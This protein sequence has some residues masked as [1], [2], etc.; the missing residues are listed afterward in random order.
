MSK[1]K[2]TLNSFL[3][4]GL[5]GGL[6]L[7]WKQ[8]VGVVVNFADKNVLD[9]AITYRGYKFF[10]SFVYGESS[11]IGKEK[12]WECLMR[13]GVG[14]RDS[15]CMVGDF[16]EIL[17]N[18]EKIGGPK[19]SDSSF[20]DFANMLKICDMAEIVGTGDPFTWA[21]QRYQK[22]I[23]CKLDRCYANKA[24]MEEGLLPSD[25]GVYGEIRIRS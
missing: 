23:Q 6:A 5:S 24:Y 8:E 16:N 11:Q 13:L 10:V 3:S 21:G 15:W 19:R 1:F 12:V 4:N 14:R 22:Y 7:L 9:C 25:S 20:M 17:N 2:S 18:E